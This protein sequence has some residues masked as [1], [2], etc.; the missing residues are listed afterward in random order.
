MQIWSAGLALATM[1]CLCGT[2]QARDI[3]RDAEYYILEAQHG[4]R[5]MAQDA[6]L[7]QKLAEFR[8]RNGGKPPNIFYILIDDIGFGDLGSET[9]NAIRGYETPGIN[10][11]A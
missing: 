1:L 7:D 5:W 4:E 6:L 3:P 10:E 8:E 9:L 2:A 11:I